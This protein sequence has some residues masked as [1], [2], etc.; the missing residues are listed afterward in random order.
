MFKLSTR[1]MGRLADVH[2]DLIKVAVRAI[3][4]TKYDF[5]ISEGLRTQALQ[6]HYVSIQRSHTRHSLHLRQKDGKS[7]ALD[8][9]ALDEHGKYTTK[10]KYYRKI[11][12]A[13]VTAAV[14]L[15]V[16]IELGGLWESLID[17]PHVQLSKKYRQ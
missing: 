11:M 14:E 6:D 17:S 13:F 4:L 5:G 9:Y 1:S 10:H 3:E 15:G 8:F 2:S 7:H 16:E 12:Q